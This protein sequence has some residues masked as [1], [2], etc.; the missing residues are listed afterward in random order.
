M[1][2]FGLVRSTRF[3]FLILS[4]FWKSLEISREYLGI[5]RNPSQPMGINL[6]HTPQPNQEMLCMCRMPD[7]QSCVRISFKVL[8]KSGQAMEVIWKVNV[9]QFLIQ[10][11]WYCALSGC[12]FSICWL[13]WICSCTVCKKTVSHHCG[14]ACVSLGYR[15][16]HTCGCTVCS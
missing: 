2:Y 15:L 14:S 3:S 11:V 4:W 6:S 12:V 1:N 13:V 9:L 7:C 10:V 8:C 16:V 5:N